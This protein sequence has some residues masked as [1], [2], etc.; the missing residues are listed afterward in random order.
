MPGFRAVLDQSRL[1]AG[2][3]RVGFMIA[4]ARGAES[5]LTDHFVSLKGSRTTE[6]ATSAH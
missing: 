3:F 6:A 2:E 1:P 5:I 4:R